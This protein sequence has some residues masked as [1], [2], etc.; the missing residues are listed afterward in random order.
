MK[1]IRCV[2]VASV[3]LIATFV[4]GCATRPVSL[5]SATTGGYSSNGERIYLTGTSDSGQPITYNGGIMMMR[6]ACVNCHGTDGHG[7]R[8]RLMM[9]SI[10][11][12][13]ITWPVLT[14][15][16][17][18]RPAYDE[19]AFKRAVTQGTDPSG[20]ELESPMPV[21]QISAGDLDDLLAFIKTLK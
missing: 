3:V 4:A 8:V 14:T 9:S 7:G 20:S 18:A 6:L 12:P 10:D 1:A 13:N 5:P 17:D 2:A 11:V 16:S 21:W 19:Q 15:A